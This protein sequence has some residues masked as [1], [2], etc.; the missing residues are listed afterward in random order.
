MDIVDDQI[1][2]VSTAVMGLSVACARCHDHEAAEFD[3][4]HPDVDL[5]RQ[6]DAGILALP[7]VGE[8]MEVAVL[9][10]EP[11]VLALPASHQL[12]ESDEVAMQDLQGA[13]LLLLEEG[14]LHSV[15]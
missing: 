6:L 9:F 10:E 5:G 13:E 11:F 1:N 7:I 15:P 12:T 4:R 8:G 3:E 14:H 2:V